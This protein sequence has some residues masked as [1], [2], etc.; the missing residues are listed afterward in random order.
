MAIMVNIA[1]GYEIHELS[2]SYGSQTCLQTISLQ[3]EAGFFYGLIGPNGSGKS[4]L[5]DVLSGFAPPSSGSVQFNG[6]PIKSYSRRE[7]SLL[8][9]TVP[10]SFSLNFDYSVEDVVLMGRNPHIERFS[11]PSALDFELV[12][13]ALK[14][15]DVYDLRQRS[16]KNLSGG[17]KQRVMIARS[18]AQDASFILLDEVTAS[19]DINHAISIMKT[20]SSLVKNKGRTII[21]ALHD[22]NMAM[23]FCD[24]VIVLNNGRLERYG[25]VS[26]VISE[27]MIRD[28]YQVQSHIFRTESGN[29]HI[30]FN[31]R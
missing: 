4:T 5:L 14:S 2:F 19:L 31:Y 26:E 15:M 22:L 30:Q 3:L 25:A 29:N 23:G 21:A 6:A 1:K 10:Q 7:L 18:L 16:V 12:N 27:D 17:E 9:S 11:S 8:L 28:L 20:M 13:S 24:R